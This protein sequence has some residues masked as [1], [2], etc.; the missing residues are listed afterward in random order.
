MS[1]LKFNALI[2]LVLFTAVYSMGQTTSFFLPLKK[3]SVNEGL[4]SS[5]TVRIEED[6]YGFIWIA[7]HDGL[8]RFDGKT[9]IHFNKNSAEH[10]SGNDVSA[11]AI[12][13]ASNLLW[14]ATALGGLDAI[15]LRT[16]KIKK[17]FLFS[18]KGSVTMND[19]V[20]SIAVT[21][22]EIWLGTNNGLF[23]YDAAKNSLLQKLPSPLLPGMDKNIRYD[24]LIF[25]GSSVVT[26]LINNSNI[27]EYDISKKK[28]IKDQ[29]IQEGP[30]QPPLLI[31]DI[32]LRDKKRILASTN[33]GVR[34]L[35]KNAAENNF[36]VEPYSAGDFSFITAA[37][38]M[39]AILNKNRELW[40]ASP[41]GV[42]RADPVRK[43]VEKIEALSGIPRDN[44]GKTVNQLLFDS[45]NNI[46]LSTSGGVLV[47]AIRPPP[48]SSL[49]NLNNGQ[50][51]VGRCFNIM[52][53]GG[54]HNYIC[55]ETG[56]IT[57]D[58][59]FTTG[60]KTDQA[61]SYYSV[62]QLS[63]RIIAFTSAGIRL[64]EKNNTTSAATAFPELTNIAAEK[65]GCWLKVND[66][67]LLLASYVNKGIWKWDINEHRVD[68]TGTDPLND[69]NTDQINS[70]YR[71]SENSVLIVYLSKIFRYNIH[72]GTLT[73]ISL[74][75]KPANCIFYD[76]IKA[77]SFYFAGTYGDGILVY[78]HNF[79][80]VKHLKDEDG[81][82]NNNIYN[83]YPFNDSTILAS[84]NFGAA[85]IHT[86]NFSI[87][88]VL[89]SDGLSSNNLEY[90]FHP[91]VTN[92]K[93]LLPSTEGVTIIQPSFFSGSKQAPR[94]YFAGITI[95]A[96]GKTTDTTDLDISAITIP[97]DFLR[98]TV[99]FATI[100]FP[101]PGR[102]KY[103]YKIQELSDDWTDR[104]NK[105]YLEL[106]GI[107]HG[108]YHLQVQAFNENSTGS[109]I[110]ELILTF[111][112]KWYQTWWFKAL[113]IAAVVI[114]GYSL[115]RMRI[116]QLKKEEKI[117]NQ[118]A[119][120]LHDDL[121]S[122]LNSIK[123]HSN[124]ALMEKEKTEH[125]SNIKQGAQD[126]ISGIRDII[127]V[128]DDKKDTLGDM[129]ARIAQFALPLCKGS[130]IIFTVS[131][132]DG[133]KET[134]LGK[135]EKR[136][137]YLIIKETINN[138]LKY[139]GCKNISLKAEKTG[140]KIRMEITDDGAGFDQTKLS[141]GYGLRNIASR[142]EAIGYTNTLITSPGKG[143]RLVLEKK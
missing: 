45:N 90:D 41:D 3:Y 22:N 98:V 28:I 138:S 71:E 6:P 54:L 64:I 17:R 96:N 31:N 49:H 130:D 21:G 32:T 23:V 104:G 89:S 97:A 86:K 107:R 24:K 33:S 141:G 121:G 92:N 44:W 10:L 127:W 1:F 95:N 108:T 29:I 135:E 48:F 113:M 83:F 74:A 142:A 118:L 61:T 85:L 7:T 25:D 46:W 125:L 4:S 124:L 117:R 105:N 109:E 128:L 103:K 19:W 133:V 20:L 62:L 82:P 126:A 136:N 91:A 116:S 16:L 100:Y 87:R 72:A 137:L 34:T 30:G 99:N 102:I 120:D 63:S 73:E 69:L 42:F 84:T 106:I 59:S 78:D 79:K 80:P 26:A 131:E 94:T 55:T 9:F 88:S 112:P 93:I 2:I 39:H 50:L 66:H 119:S 101:D 53:T 76:I 129:L 40:F 57:T 114:I 70:L 68:Y 12:D 123:V 5:T 110:K 65:I 8:N 52:T 60:V 51:P 140:K 143:V 81:L 77:G 58:S 43:K 115:Y 111:L 75:D 132:D 37:P 122:T 47:S 139:S 38:V 56:L 13:S 27:T 134:K 11:I 36:R 35:S 18:S 67:I 14:S 15:D